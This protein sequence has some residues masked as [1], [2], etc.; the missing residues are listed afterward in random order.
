MSTFFI[1]QDPQANKA[2]FILIT[3]DEKFYQLYD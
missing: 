1:W 2:I 3:Y